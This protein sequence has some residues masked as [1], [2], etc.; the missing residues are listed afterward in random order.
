VTGTARR[1]DL[2]LS[3]LRS[4]DEIERILIKTYKEELGTMK[5]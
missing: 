4:I 3:R 1:E 2:R 5:T